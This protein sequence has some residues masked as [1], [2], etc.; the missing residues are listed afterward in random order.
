MSQFNKLAV[1]AIATWSGFI[2]EMQVTP[3]S[4]QFLYQLPDVVRA[5]WNCPPVADLTATLPCAT[6]TDIVALWTSSPM[7]MLHFIW[8]LPNS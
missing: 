8:S 4:A 1:Q 2:A 7:N 5:V 6:A 3:T